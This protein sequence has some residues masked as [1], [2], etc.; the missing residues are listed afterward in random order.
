MSFW[1]EDDIDTM[2][3]DSPN[4]MTVNAVTQPVWFDDSDE[5]MLSE[6]AGYTAQIIN[7][8]AVNYKTAHF[9]DLKVGDV[10]SIDGADCKIHKRLKQGD[11]A[12]TQLIVGDA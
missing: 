2:L 6:G 9:P 8:R 1:F 7:I 12:L 3:E 11:G 4:S 10:V 5:A